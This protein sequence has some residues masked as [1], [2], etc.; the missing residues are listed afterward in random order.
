[1][2]VDCIIVFLSANWAADYGQRTVY[3]NRQADCG[4]GQVQA[5]QCGVQLDARSGLL[6]S[7]PDRL[8]AWLPAYTA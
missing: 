7:Q 2:P 3:S 8:P 5:E 4:S 1:M 6:A